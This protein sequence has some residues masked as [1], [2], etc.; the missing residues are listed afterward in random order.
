VILF[1]VDYYYL[2]DLGLIAGVGGT[3]RK[4]LLCFDDLVLHRINALNA[5]A[6]D[7]VLSADPLSVLKY[8]EMGMD[9]EYLCLEASA[10]IY[11]EGPPEKDID[12]LH[13]GSLKADRREFIDHLLAKG[14][15]LRLI[16]PE[17]GYVSQDELVRYIGRSRIVLN[18]A[19]TDF[20]ETTDLG[21]EQTHR[22]YLQFKGRVVEAGLCHAACV[23]E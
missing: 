23:S 14:T 16:G 3:A 8:R 5:S 6:C 15:P 11:V 7:I 12:V 1:D 20:A 13:F 4:A 17:N 18:F 10:E 9:A 22:Y 19:K 21:I 2:F